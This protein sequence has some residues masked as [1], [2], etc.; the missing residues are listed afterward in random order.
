[1]RATKVHR[2]YVGT[3]WVIEGSGIRGPKFQSRLVYPL[4]A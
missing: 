2:N 4:G 3:I 1:M